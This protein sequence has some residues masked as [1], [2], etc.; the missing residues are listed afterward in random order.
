MNRKETE[1][2][3]IEIFSKKF[4]RLNFKF[5]KEDGYSSNHSFEFATDVGLFHYE[6]SFGTSNRWGNLTFGSGLN[7]AHAAITDIY[8]QIDPGYDY[9]YFYPLQIGL[10]AYIHPSNGIYK[11]THDAVEMDI[12]HTL[13]SKPI[14]AVANDLFTLFYAPMFDTLIPS[15]DSIEK[16]DGIINGFPDVFNYEKDLHTIQ[17]SNGLADQFIIGLIT[18]KLLGRP[19]YSKLADR[20]LYEYKEYA[21]GSV[22]CADLLRKAVAM[23]ENKEIKMPH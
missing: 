22:E 12:K 21:P 18:A 6:L 14:E 20:Y 4:E 17:Y 15:L 16:L 9:E 10:N 1:K 23:F 19:D 7:I 5:I 13:L 8:K 2:K 3:L 11:Y